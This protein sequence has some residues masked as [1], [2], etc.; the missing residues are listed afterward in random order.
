MGGSP[1]RKISSM[2]HGLLSYSS[3]LFMRIRRGEK[4]D[5]EEENQDEEDEEK[6]QRT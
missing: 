5:E 4:E 2:D 3:F 6:F 1:W